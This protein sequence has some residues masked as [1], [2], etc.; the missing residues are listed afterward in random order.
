MDYNPIDY[1][2]EEA[3]VSIHLAFYSTEP[4]GIRE[5]I[6]QGTRKGAGLNS[7]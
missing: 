3:T 6:H 5:G 4:E 7:D 2:G 1:S